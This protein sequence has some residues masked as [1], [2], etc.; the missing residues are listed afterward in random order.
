MTTDHAL[1]PTES[2]APSPAARRARRFG[3]WFYVTVM[4]L[5]P[6]AL[7]LAGGVAFWLWW[8]WEDLKAA[9][10]VKAEVARIQALGEPVTIHDLYAWHRV[11]E[12]TNDT[13]ALWLAAFRASGSINTANSK[14]SQVPIVSRGDRATL[15]ADAPNSTLDLADAFLKEHDAA[16]QAIL[17]ASAAQGQCRMPYAFENGAAANMRLIQDFRQV[18]RLLS[19]RTR[20][21]VAHDDSKTA[22]ESVEANLALARAIDHEPTLV[23][24]LVR[25]AVLGVVLNDIELL[26]S[27]LPLTEEQLAQLQH[28]MQTL[29]LQN[30]FTSS[31]VGE[32]GIG[33]HAFH[34]FPPPPAPRIAT[35][36]QPMAS[37][38]L[39]RPADCRFYLQM[40]QE[41]IDASRQPFPKAIQDSR[42]IEGR[43]ATVAQSTNPLERMRYVQSMTVVP[44]MKAAISASARTEAIHQLTL[45]AI[46]AQRYQLKHG[47]WPSDLESLSEF[48]RER[49]LDPY[50]GKP[51]RMVVKGD[52]L[53]LYCIGEDEID[54]G[55]QDPQDNFRPDIVVRLKIVAR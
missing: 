5:A 18:A 26:L 38:K 7:V 11:P 28:R 46:T 24:Q 44:A 55:G 54:N 2:D 1:P 42:Q 39:W 47:Q 49:P 50:D 52:E 36:A 51:V 41:Y 16:F 10:D 48:L 20:V 32:R 8:K 14:Y 35:A 45:T 37:G 21:A 34:N 40:M 4:V 53:I 6:F 15:A 13:T 3:W 25:I 30:S 9:Q 43:V 12:G 17:T 22:I 29:D 27:D 23:G 31:L 19:L 33:F